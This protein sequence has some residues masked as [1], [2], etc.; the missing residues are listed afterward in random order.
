M[1]PSQP[2]LDLDSSYWSELETAYGSGAGIPALLVQ[3][4]EFPLMQSYRDEPWFSLWSALCHQ[5]DVYSASFAAVPHIVAALHVDPVSA[6]F[7]YFQFPACIELARLGKGLQVPTKLHF[8]YR[9]AIADL[10]E[11]AAKAAVDNWPDEKCAVALAATAVA[12]K[13]YDLA[14]LLIEIEPASYREIVDRV[15]ES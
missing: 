9:K 10:P 13:K 14:R 1:E 15:L 4:K 8:A 12:T 11:L 2:L 5:G 6:D 3:L 7:N